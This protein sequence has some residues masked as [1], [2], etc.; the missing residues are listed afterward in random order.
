MFVRPKF[1]MSAHESIR[2]ASIYS[3]TVWSQFPCLWPLVMMVMSMEF[4]GCGTRAMRAHPYRSMCSPMPV[5]I[6]RDLIK[7][8]AHTI[9]SQ[10]VCPHHPSLPETGLRLSTHEDLASPLLQAGNPGLFFQL[11]YPPRSGHAFVPSLHVCSRLS[12]VCPHSPRPNTPCQRVEN[13]ALATPRG[14]PRRTRGRLRTAT[15]EIDRIHTLGW[16]QLRGL[17]A[18]WAS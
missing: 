5:R 7:E 8:H 17:K 1:V 11:F 3:A 13:R 12:H 18:Q 10:A 9:T 16:Q 15:I 6:L 14:K 2:I 4:G